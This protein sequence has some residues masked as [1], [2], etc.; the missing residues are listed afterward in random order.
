[1]RGAMP[2]ATLDTAAAYAMCQDRCASQNFAGLQL[3]TRLL[4]RHPLPL[5]KDSHE[6]VR[7][8]AYSAS[9]CFAGMA[10]AKAGISRQALWMRLI[11]G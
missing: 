5:G 7:Y 2:G 4:R 3:L 1:M 8:T 9:G 11:V 10:A 6:P